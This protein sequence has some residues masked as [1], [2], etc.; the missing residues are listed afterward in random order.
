[1]QGRGISSIF[2]SFTFALN[3][4]TS[5]LSPP[6]QNSQIDLSFKKPIKEPIGDKREIPRTHQVEVD[7]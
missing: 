6:L 1:M 3:C 7:L 5:L 2:F 4:E